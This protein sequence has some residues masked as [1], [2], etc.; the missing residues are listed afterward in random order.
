[1]S[2][3]KVKA[4][5]T[6]AGS[7]QASHGA[8]RQEELGFPIENESA[9]DHRARPTA[10]F[11][12]NRT[13][14][15]LE[16]VSLG[17][18]RWSRWIAV[19]GGLG[20]VPVAPGTAGSL[21]GV[22]LF[23]LMSRV[24]AEAVVVSQGRLISIHAFGIVA[25]LLLGIRAAGRAEIDFGRRDDGRIVID[26]VV[27]Q[28]LALMPLLWLGSFAS[29]S[30]SGSEA[31]LSNGPPVSLLFFFEV[32]TGF[33]LFRLFDVWK[34]GAVRWAERRFEGGLGVMAD[35]VMAGIHAALCL[36]ILH[37]LVFE[38][39]ESASLPGAVEATGAAGAAVSVLGIVVPGL[40]AGRSGVV[41]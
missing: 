12:E 3:R 23:V 34:P 30:P 13:A 28:W 11:V 6:E 36:L 14:E 27:G 24:L 8:G 15:D 26:E 10:D 9:H 35:D 29:G 17:F 39:F 20:Y 2:R 1:M 7:K 19:V 41:S 4:C 22:V 21:G 5:P 18:G 31:A 37:A 25:L 33:V 16:R 38:R 32:V 40:L